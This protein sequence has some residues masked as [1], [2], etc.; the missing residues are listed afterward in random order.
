[1]DL[2]FSIQVLETNVWPLKSLNMIYV[3]SASQLAVLVQYNDYDTLTS[4]ELMANTG[5]PVDI[6]KQVL[7][8]LTKACLLRND[9]EGSQG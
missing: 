4:D 9:S 3:A 8:I 6:L 5:I 2:T 7:A 1:M